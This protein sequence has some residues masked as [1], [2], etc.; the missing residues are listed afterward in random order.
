MGVYRSYDEGATWVSISTGLPAAQPV[1]FMAAGSLYLYAVCN[2]QVWR[3][4]IASALGL[5][6]VDGHTQFAIYPNPSATGIFSIA[7]NGSKLENIEVYNMSGA[8]ILSSIK[9]EKMTID[10]SGHPKGVY[11]YSVRTKDGKIEVGKLIVE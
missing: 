7:G 6:N 4:T 8:K 3:N 10:L 9:T 2:G 5:E 1:G 11:P